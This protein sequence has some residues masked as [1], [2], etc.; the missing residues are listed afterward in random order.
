MIW[1][2]CELIL[3]VLCLI[4]VMFM[5]DNCYVY[6]SLLVDEL[7]FIFLLIVSFPNTILINILEPTHIGLHLLID[8]PNMRHILPKRQWLILIKHMTLQVPKCK[9]PHL[10]ICWR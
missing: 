1:A 8:P 7:D 6:A 10:L 4:I 3:F 5:L 2:G 9:P